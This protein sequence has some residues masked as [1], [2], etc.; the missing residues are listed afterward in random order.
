MRKLETDKHKE[1]LKKS[2]K[3]IR[4]SRPTVVSNLQLSYEYV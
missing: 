3:K 2:K 1:I 4:V